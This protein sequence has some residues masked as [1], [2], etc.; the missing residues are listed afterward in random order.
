M[1]SRLKNEL[2]KEIDYL[3]GYRK[4]TAVLAFNVLESVDDVNSFLDLK[5][6]L[7]TVELT[8][9]EDEYRIQDVAKMLHHLFNELML[10]DHLSDGMKQKLAERTLKKKEIKLVLEDDSEE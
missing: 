3:E 1:K 9:L 8:L 7:T 5:S 2:K 6:T 10:N 4:Q